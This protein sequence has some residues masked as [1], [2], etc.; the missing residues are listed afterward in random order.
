MDDHLTRVQARAPS[1]SQ[2]WRLQWPENLGPEGKANWEVEWFLVFFSVAV[3]KSKVG[4]GKDLFGL[5]L[6]VTVHH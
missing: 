6:D 3:T 2:Q 4:R 1:A 5:H